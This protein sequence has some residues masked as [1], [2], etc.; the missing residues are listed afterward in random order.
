MLL[1]FDLTLDSMPI[2]IEHLHL[3][4]RQIQIGIQFHRYDPTIRAG[5]GTLVFWY[6]TC[7]P[8]LPC[9]FPTT[10]AG[11]LHGFFLSTPRFGVGQMQ[12]VGGSLCLLVYHT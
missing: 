8:R 10:Y 12:D 6:L 3:I 2:E 9:R 7:R 4:D 1:G 5:L 11:G